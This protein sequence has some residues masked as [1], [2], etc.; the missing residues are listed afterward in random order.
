METGLKRILIN[1][2]VVKYSMVKQK[3]VN[4]SILASGTLIFI[5]IG[6]IILL[7][8]KLPFDDKSNR[9]MLWKY[10]PELEGKDVFVLSYVDPNDLASSEKNDP[11]VQLTGT[12]LNQ[13]PQLKDAVLE[14]L[15]LT[16]N[17]AIDSNSTNHLSLHVRK[18]ILIE[19]LEKIKDFLAEKAKC[20]SDSLIHII[21]YYHDP[22]LKETLYFRFIT[23]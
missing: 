5:I 15:N 21:F 22:E 11:V 8:I 18:F 2:E 1:L 9:G 4:Y 17:Q 13:Y 20:P 12:E 14:L 3:A 19:D 10:S 6:T 23:Y 7:G 16:L